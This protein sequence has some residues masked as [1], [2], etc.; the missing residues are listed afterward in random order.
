MEEKRTTGKESDEALN[1]KTVGT[2]NLVQGKT[3]CRSGWKGNAGTNDTK[4]R[5]G[6][7]C[8]PGTGDIPRLLVHVFNRDA[9]KY[10]KIFLKYIKGC[11]GAIP[12]EYMELLFVKS[13]YVLRGSIAVLQGYYSDHSYI[14]RKASTRKRWKVFWG[15]EVWAW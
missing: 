13:G 12:H 9:D 6:C 3:L 7:V 15:C 10:S 11:W 4:G 5:W 14:G 2:R 8:W 1:Y